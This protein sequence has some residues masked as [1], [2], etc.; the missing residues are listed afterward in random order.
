MDT[1]QDMQDVA[2]LWDS[3]INNE[4]ATYDEL[5]LVTDLNGYTVD[6]L[7]SVLFARN[8]YHDWERSEERR[9]GKEC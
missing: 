4:I 9:V 2:D 8:G 1:S 6:T 7:N 5:K 3:L